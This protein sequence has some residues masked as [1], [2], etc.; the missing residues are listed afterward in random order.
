MMSA[1]EVGG[2]HGKVD[3]AREVAGILFHKSVPNA[4][5]GDWVKNTKNFADVIN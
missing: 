2:G 4:D 3:I 1:S 5:K